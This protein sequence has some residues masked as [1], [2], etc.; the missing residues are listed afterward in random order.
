LVIVKALYGSFSDLNNGVGAPGTF[1][2]V[3]AI[4][5]A[6]VVNHATLSFAI[7]NS[8]MGGDPA[9]G[10][11]KYFWLSYTTNGVAATKWILE[12]QTITAS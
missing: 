6:L 9:P 4:I 7:T 1:T 5:A 10:I 3:T 8:S 2:D 12:G 11:G